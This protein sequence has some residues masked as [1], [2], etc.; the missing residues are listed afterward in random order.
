MLIRGIRVCFPE[1]KSG[2][3]R[4]RCSNIIENKVYLAYRFLYHARCRYKVLAMIGF[5]FAVVAPTRRAGM[6]ELQTE[7]KYA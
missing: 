5:V 7:P 2:E 6:G 1:C 4:Q 3:A